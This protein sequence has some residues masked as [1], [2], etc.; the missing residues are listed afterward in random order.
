MEQKIE[1]LVDETERLSSSLHL[2][3]ISEILF[4]VTSCKGTF[5]HGCLRL[6]HRST[7]I[8]R[9][10]LITRKRLRGSYKAVITRN[11]ERTAR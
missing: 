7:T 3:F 4:Q 9:V 6:T 8:S 11:G 10:V 5:E 2:L 1:Q